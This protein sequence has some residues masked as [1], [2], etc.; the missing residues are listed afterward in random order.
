MTQTADVIV[1]GLGGMGSAT[2][3]QL[4]RRGKRVIGLEQFGAAHERGSS[5]GKS[6]IIRQAYFEH[7]DYVPLL[8]RA[9]ELWHELQAGSTDP[10]LTITGG[11]MIGTSDSEVVQGAAL[12]ARS[13]GLAHELL[14]APDLRRRFP[15]FAVR[16]DEVALYETQ[17]GVLHPELT[18]LAHLAG[19]ARHGADLHFNEPVTGWQATAGG[20]VRV[21]TAQGEYEAGH[22]VVAA[23]A[24]AARLLPELALP[25]Q[26]DRQVLYWFA[27]T[28]PLSD[29]AV[30]RLPIYIWEQRDGSAFYGFPAQDGPPGGVKVAFHTGG[31]PSD[32]DTIR[33]VVS[34]DEVAAMRAALDGRIPGLAGELLA[35]ATCM[36][37]MT[38]DQHFI[39]APHAQ[40]PQVTVASPCSGHGYKFCAV[41]GEILADLA[42]DGTTRH[43]IDLFRLGRF[44]GSGNART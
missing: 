38:P 9:Y 11:L 36:Y 34:A 26:V 31:T 41:V 25:L 40:L 39:I 23:G 24:W 27:P 42:T 30:G 37:T 29:F 20:G 17:A 14:D 6:R 35:T 19:A 28:R 44:A 3:Y 4:A 22:L 13:Y 2:A 43:P 16:D 15:Q 32:A 21:I 1:I 33:R 18:V 10:L 8:L 12:S 5:H 7:P